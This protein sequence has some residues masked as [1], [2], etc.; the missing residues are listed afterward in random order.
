MKPWRE[1]SWWHELSGKAAVI[2]AAYHPT[3]LVLLYVPDEVKNTSCV[4][5][6]SL[7][8]ATF[9]SH[10]QNQPTKVQGWHSFCVSL[11]K[12]SQVLSF[13]LNRPIFHQ[14]LCACGRI[15][16]SPPPFKAAA[17]W[18]FSKLWH[19]PEKC[20]PRSSIFII[21]NHCESNAR[22]TALSL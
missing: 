21:S 16:V 2:A 15:C 1:S 20:A 8:F 4:I 22:T 13:C 12:T 5:T 9:C 11:W 18:L 14:T 19:H 3:L 10:R 7:T 6:A 17:C